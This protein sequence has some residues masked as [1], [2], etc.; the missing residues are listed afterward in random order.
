[1]RP[2]LD[3]V[4]K[5]G[6]SEEVSLKSTR[7]RGK[8]P[9]EGKVRSVPGRQNDISKDPQAESQ[10]GPSLV[11]GGESEKRAWKGQHRTQEVTLKAPDDQ[12]QV[13]QTNHKSGVSPSF[14]S[15]FLHN[16]RV[17]NRSLKSASSG[18]Y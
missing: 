9:A 13:G 8:K 6:S 11:K 17:H 2:T 18:R 7:R 1:M 3:W 15:L 12:V 4:A 10:C 14:C 5:E 16:P